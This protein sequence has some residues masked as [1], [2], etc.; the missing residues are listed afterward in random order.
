MG[1]LAGV[2]VVDFTAMVSGPMAAAMLADQGAEVIKVEPPAGDE[3]R[4]IGQR[5]NGLTGGLLR[6]QPGQALPVHRLE[7]A[8]GRSAGAQTHR[9]RRCAHAELPPRRHA[10]SWLGRGGAAGVVAEADLR[11]HQRLR[12]ARPL[13]SP[14]GL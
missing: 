6:L 13:R 8:G 9:I 12:R 2:R 7:K 1:P 4:R 14:A 10:A 5:R 11:F 3:S